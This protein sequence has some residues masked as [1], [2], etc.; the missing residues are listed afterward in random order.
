MALYR[1]WTSRPAARGGPAKRAALGPLAVVAALLSGCGGDAADP[2]ASPS[3]VAVAGESF[4][5]PV[6]KP[7]GESPAAGA[8]DPAAA[9]APAASAGPIPTLGG[10][11]RYGI[12]STAVPGVGA[13]LDGTVPFAATDPWNRDVSTAPVDAASSALIAAIGAQ[14]SLRPGFGALAGVPY[15]VVDRSQPRRSVAPADGG[16]ARDWP[17]PPTLGLSADASARLA[18]LDRDAGVLYELRGAVL[19]A[20]GGW[21]AVAGSSRRLDGSSGQAQDTFGADAADGGMPTFAGL[22]RRDE[23]ASGVIRHAL[24]V[25]VPAL[26]TAWVAPATHA[27]E[28]A[29]D[30]ALPAIGLRLRLRAD[31]SIPADAG[32]QA[33]AILQAL[34]TYGMIVTG[35]GPALALEGAPDAGWDLAGLSADLARIR[36]ADFEV[37]AAE[38]VAPR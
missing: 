25:T 31:V 35:T 34:R 33:R 3:A 15:A 29:H 6:S 22:L 37:L 10:K 1:I 26:R 11:V 4:V 24:R 23:A 14:A 36:G 18:V 12:P 38:P 27:A 28:G 19:G 16:A 13:A 5:A 20:D 2:A 7:L 21:T 32:P 17:I 9:S 30:P 8:T